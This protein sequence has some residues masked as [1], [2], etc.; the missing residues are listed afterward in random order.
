[1]GKKEVIEIHRHAHNYG[2]NVF[3]TAIVKIISVNTV[4]VVHCKVI[5]TRVLVMVSP[6]GN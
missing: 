3:G 1:M 4:Y 5:N 6:H 2:W